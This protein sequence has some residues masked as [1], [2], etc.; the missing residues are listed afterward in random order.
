MTNKTWTPPS[1]QQ[2]FDNAC[3]GIIGQGMR[4]AY[5]S[6]LELCQAM[7]EDGTRCAIAH[8]CSDVEPG[9]TA[10]P[11]WRQLTKYDSPVIALSKWLI[12]AHDRVLVEAGGVK[13]RTRMAEIALEFGLDDSCLY[14]VLKETP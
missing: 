3:L 11:Q 14:F 1:P 12:D 9:E 5:D 8:S 13:W 4:A 2:L 7:A 10:S 6:E